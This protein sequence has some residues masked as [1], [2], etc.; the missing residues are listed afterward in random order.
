M[1]VGYFDPL[2]NQT[3]A[4]QKLRKLGWNDIK[5][6]DDNLAYKTAVESLV[7]VKNEGVLPLAG[8]KSIALVGPMAN[9][10]TSCSP[11]LIMKF[12]RG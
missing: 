11:K 10:K 4:S 5:N 2:G 7:L 1:S 9:G 3:A 8:N 6:T 12:I